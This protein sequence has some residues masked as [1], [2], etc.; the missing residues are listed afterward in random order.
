MTGR[1]TYDFAVCRTLVRARELGAVFE[2]TP[3]GIGF[4]APART[5]AKVQQ[6]LVGADRW[7]PAY[8]NAFVAA[9]RKLTGTKAAGGGDAA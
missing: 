8:R 9:V 3:D 6:L 2:A 7:H 1:V 4:T 5:E